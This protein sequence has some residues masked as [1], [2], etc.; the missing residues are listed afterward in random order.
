MNKKFQN[1]LLID[2]LKTLL[3]KQL[4]IVIAII[5]LLFLPALAQSKRSFPPLLFQENANIEI[6]SKDYT[7]NVGMEAWTLFKQG[8]SNGNWQPILDITSE[9]FQF[10]F[11]QG[12]F[13]DYMKV[14]MASAYLKN[15]L[16]FMPITTI[17]LKVMPRQLPLVVTIL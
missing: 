6:E 8:W 15:G 4:I 9:D 5:L 7:L 10:W 12:G 11:P 2:N 16:S 17:P 13:V 14:R 1:L 3:T